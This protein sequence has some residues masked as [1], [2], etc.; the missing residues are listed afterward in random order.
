MDRQ[1]V[2]QDAVGRP[3]LGEAEPP[4]E[5]TGPVGEVGQLRVQGDESLQALVL[6]P[7]PAGHPPDLPGPAP[8]AAV[9]VCERVVR[10]YRTER[11]AIVRRNGHGSPRLAIRSIISS[12]ACTENWL[13]F[14]TSMVTV[15]WLPLGGIPASD[16]Q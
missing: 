1:Q 2:P 13:S 12:S 11:L 16:I 7:D 14:G 9:E 15:A 3:P 6:R 4:D 10:A 8:A 5:V